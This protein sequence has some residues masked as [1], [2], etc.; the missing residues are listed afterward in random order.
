VSS[1]SISGSSAIVYGTNSGTA[2]ISICQN[3][4]QCATLYVTV[5][6]PTTPT[7][8]V[9]PIITPVQT[10][11]IFTRNLKYNDKGED[12][13]QLQKILVKLGYLTATPN[14][15]YGPATI[16]GVKKLQAAHNIKQLGIVGPA[17]KDLNSL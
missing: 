5:S 8:P 15:R 17:T 11:Y 13:L 14:G 2:N 4:G 3:G 12:V 6:A 1:I 16:S 10:S 9:T 7:T